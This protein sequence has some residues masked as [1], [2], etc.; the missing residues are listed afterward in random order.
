MKRTGPTN[1]IIRR[2]IREL[3]KASNKHSAR[4]WK[5]IA[6]LLMRP[7]RKRVAVNISK[8]RRYTKPGDIVVVPGKVLGAGAIDHSVTVAALS[9]SASAIEK[10]KAAGGR[11]MH[12]LELVK[13]RPK[14]SGV[15]IIT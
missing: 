11:T 3:I 2:T 8:I 10:I 13:E 4:I 1:Y 9:F 6:G 14:G 5:Y 12:I 15:R 7:S